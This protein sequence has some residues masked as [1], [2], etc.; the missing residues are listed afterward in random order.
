MVKLLHYLSTAPTPLTQLTPVLYYRILYNQLTWIERFWGW[1]TKSQ[2]SVLLWARGKDHCYTVAAFRHGS[3]TQWLKKPSSSVS[4]S[5]CLWSSTQ[6]L[7]KPLS[8]QSIANLSENLFRNK[9]SL[10]KK[11]VSGIM[12][13]QCLSFY[14]CWLIG[15]VWF[16]QL[17]T[18]WSYPRKGKHNWDNTCIR[19]VH[20]QACGA[21]FIVNDWCRR[22]QTT[23]GGAT[24][25]Q[26][27]WAV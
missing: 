9:G 2:L 10:E 22:A 25:G 23:L 13:T 11:L 7:Q 1:F 19:L 14:V 27:S 6:D 21:F 3:K 20:R 5:V 15:L 17:D 4:C 8:A 24:P 18:S 26:W 16:C 12:W